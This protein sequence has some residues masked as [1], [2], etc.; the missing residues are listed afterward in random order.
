LIDDRPIGTALNRNLGS[1]T[2][3]GEAVEAELD[4]FIEKRAA[5]EDPEAKEELWVRSVERYT[6][7]KQEEM[8]AAWCE[9]H[10]GQA[11]RHRSILEALIEHHEKQAANLQDLQEG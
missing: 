1:A 4:A 6:A 5:L 7:R 9:Y 11:A 3:L 8:R 2:A 10:Q